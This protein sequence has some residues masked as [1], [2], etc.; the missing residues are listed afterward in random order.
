MPFIKIAK[1]RKENFV[2]EPTECRGVPSRKLRK[3]RKGRSDMM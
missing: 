2:A 3:K 1:T